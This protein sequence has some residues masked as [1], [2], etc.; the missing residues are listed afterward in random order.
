MGARYI[1]GVDEAGRGPLAGPLALGVISV[2]EDFDIKAAFPGLND[3]KQVLPEKRE[4]LF[5][6]LKEYEAKNVIRYS[7]NFASHRFIDSRGITPAAK[8][9]AARGIRT[10][11]PDPEEGKIFL[12]GLLKAPRGYEQETIIHGDALVP[13]IMLA[14]IAAKVTR[15]RFMVRM[16]KRYPAYGFEQHKGYGTPE[17]IEKLRTYG[18]CPVHRLSFLSNIL[19]ASISV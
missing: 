8:F 12:D 5:S 11:L 10:L 18:S 6:I 19:S 3:S 9:A 7:V 13:A 1:L 15:D 16:A 14:S 2:Q 17:H 4:E